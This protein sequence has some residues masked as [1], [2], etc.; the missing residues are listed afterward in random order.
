L[1]AWNS[2]EPQ[3][4]RAGFDLRFPTGHFHTSSSLGKQWTFVNRAQ[5]ELLLIIAGIDLVTTNFRI[6]TITYLVT[7]N[8]SRFG[9]KRD[10]RFLIQ[11]VKNSFFLSRLMNSSDETM[12]LRSLEWRVASKSNLITA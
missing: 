11:Q 8:I 7:A 3:T 12:V 4:T 9:A 10:I 2:A 1:Y 6:G 5:A